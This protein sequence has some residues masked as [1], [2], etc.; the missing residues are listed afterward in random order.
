MPLRPC[1]EPGCKA[2][3]KRGRCAYHNKKRVQGQV[4]SRGNSAKRGYGSR[5]RRERLSFL[6]ENPYCVFCKNAGIVQIAE[7]VDHI[8]DHKG[9]YDRMWDQSN[10]QPLC[11]KCH[12]QKT[13]RENSRFLSGG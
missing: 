2:L 9:D 1:I 4:E 11:G 10:W 6:L 12:R 13:V 3:V 5:W 8:I 7:V